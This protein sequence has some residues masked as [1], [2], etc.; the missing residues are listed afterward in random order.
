MPTYV[1]IYNRLPSRRI[2]PDVPP[3]T[4]TGENPKDALKEAF[5]YSFRRVYGEAAKS[6]D[7]VLI[8]GSIEDGSIV[9]EKGA[10]RKSYIAVSKVAKVRVNNENSRTKFRDPRTNRY[11]KKEA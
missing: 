5:K 1:L 7:I 11:T 9:H 10:S 2:G 6:P 3:A 8:E 4:V